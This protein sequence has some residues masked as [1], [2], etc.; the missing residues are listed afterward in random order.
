VWTRAP[1]KRE[2]Q[3]K[4][5]KK[6]GLSELKKRADNAQ[7]IAQE[8]ALYHMGNYFWH[9]KD[10]VQAKNYWQPLIIKY[11]SRDSKTQSGYIDL[12]KAKLR[13]ISADF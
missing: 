13:L 2:R 3:R 7:D 8:A 5:L 1:R 10:F 4:S 12:V 6:E 11:G 9:K